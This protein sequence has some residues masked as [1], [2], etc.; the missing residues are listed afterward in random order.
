[1]KQML[2]IYI[3]L[4]ITG[5]GL[6]ATAQAQPALLPAAYPAD[7]KVNLVRT[8]NAVRPGLDSGNIRN[9]PIKDVKQTTAYFD[10]LGRPLQTVVK[11][12][13]QATGNNAADMVSA[14]VYDEFGREQYQYLPFAAGNAG[15]NTSIADGKFKLNPFAQQQAYMQAQYGTPTGSGGQGETF[16]YGKTEYEASPL[17]RPGKAMPPGNSW[18]GSNRGVQSKYW[19]NTISDSVK[20]WTVTNGLMGTFATYATAG[21]YLP[22]E[23]YKVVV[24]DEHGK[25]TIEYKDKAGKV[26][27]KK[28]Q[29]TAADDTG[30]GCGYTGW[31][32]TYYIF[33]EAGNLRC[34]LQPL[35][36][37]E[38]AKNNWPPIAASILDEL[39]FRYEYDTRNRMSMKKVPGAAP[40]YMVYDCVTGWYLCRMETYVPAL[41]NGSIHNMMH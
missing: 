20:I 22:G 24:V 26:I 32:C 28:V 35:S 19:I 25:Q 23:L 29:L 39:C 27:L 3:T 38:L 36:V 13:S 21:N 4:L 33:D 18:V 40:V 8:W 16:F 15:G 34:V 9:Q 10:G 1:L 31:L 37:E 17:N 7:I 2:K 14:V 5:M 11:Q 12:G 30:T 41:Q 6:F